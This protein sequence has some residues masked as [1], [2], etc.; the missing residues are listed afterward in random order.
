VI[1]AQAQAKAV[2]VDALH[3]YLQTTS[4]NPSAEHSA[5]QGLRK[6]LQAM[7]V[8]WLVRPTAPFQPTKRDAHWWSQFRHYPKRRLHAGRLVAD[9]HAAF[10]RLLL[11]LGNLL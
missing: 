11:L 8:R 5:V 3:F 1:K 6:P 9:R 7:G 10:W 2:D 4:C